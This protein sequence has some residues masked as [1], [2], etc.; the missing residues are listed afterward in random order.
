MNRKF[1]PEDDELLIGLVRQHPPLYNVTRRRY[2]DLVLKNN[3]WGEIG[4]RM[5]RS[6]KACK[7]RWKNIRD[8]YQKRKRE[9]MKGQTTG[10]ARNT[11]M[12]N[13][14]AKYKDLTFLDNTTIIEYDESDENSESQDIQVDVEEFQ[15]PVDSKASDVTQNFVITKE[16]HED[17]LSTIEEADANI[18]CKR[19]RRSVS[20]E[21]EQVNE[22]IRKGRI[23]R[24]LLV[25]DVRSQP[26]IDTREEETPISTFFRSI[27]LT[28]EQLPPDLQTRA[29]VKVLQ[30][31]S[32]LEFEQ[33][34]RKFGSS[35]QPSTIGYIIGPL[36]TN[37]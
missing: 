21:R 19:E 31:I 27:A 7:T 11:Q 23:E 34:G 15:D 2:K 4:V 8:N 33:Q 5:K 10:S 14:L 24:T 6:E 13:F 16:Y 32:E 35:S 37:R 12:E 1:S 26:R 36:P 22:E 25:K 17:Q 20:K 9:L 29:K 3:I 28:V 18:A 30:V